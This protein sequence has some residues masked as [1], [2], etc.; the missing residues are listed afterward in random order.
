M[1]ETIT[2][3][4]VTVYQNMASFKM[5]G[6]YRCKA[7][8]NEIL[9]NHLTKRM[10]KDS[11]R[12]NGSGPGKLVNIL[13]ERVYSNELVKEKIKELTKERDEKLKIKQQLDD[14]LNDATNFKVKS[15]LALER[16]AQE[17]PKWF[18]FGKIDLE[19][20]KNMNSLF[21]TQ[22]TEASKQIRSL[23]EQIEKIQ[24]EIDRLNA[25]IYELGGGSSLDSE[26]HHKIVVVIDA[27]KASDFQ[28]ELSFMVQDAYWVP[29][30][31]IFIQDSD[32][33]INLMANI[34]NHTEIDWN[35]VEMNVSTATSEP[36]KLEKPEPYTINH[37]SP[38]RP[39]TGRMYRHYGGAMMN[40]EK[41]VDAKLDL[42]AQ[43][44]IAFEM[45]PEDKPAPE[46]MEAEPMSTVDTSM[47]SNY[48][49][50]SYNLKSKFSIPSDKNPKPVHLFKDKLPSV[51]QYFWTTASPNR[52]L[53]NNKIKNK[54]RL[55]L[56]GQANVYVNDEYMGSSELS[57]IAP[58]QE[59][60]LGERLTYDV[61]VKKFLKNKNAQ[62]EG[63]LKGKKSVSY[64]YEI[65]IEN[66]AGVKE[67]LI[68]YERIPY[69][70]SER[71]SVKVG[72]FSEKYARNVM[73]VFKFVLNMSEIKDKKVISYDYDVVYEKD[74]N[75]Y[76]ALP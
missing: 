1:S 29:F 75:I 50:Q 15:N 16:F 32:V 26:V 4:E 51:I 33:D 9:V 49:V 41:D 25:V 11:V 40:T 76:P 61:R 38:V 18:S 60:K 67:E 39:T 13:V 24:L 74:V 70:V 62:K 22:I 30:Y 14:D 59:F 45:S 56:P 21:Q 54:D 48:G 58:N 53:C 69:S 5:I 10:V 42:V 2:L 55:L 12:V 28:V 6:T 63:V 34:H 36:V 37:I 73:N 72:T 27:E 68:L 57:L 17:F 44:N 46:P 66:L 3:K 8:L 20:V 65:E 7:G 71:I 19:S 52:V 31:D 35:D 64:S 43:S 47:I 23:S